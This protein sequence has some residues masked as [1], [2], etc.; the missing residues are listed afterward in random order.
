MGGNI[1][2]EMDNIMRE[3]ELELNRRLERKYSKTV[4]KKIIQLYDS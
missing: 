2:E 3:E 4:A 1:Q